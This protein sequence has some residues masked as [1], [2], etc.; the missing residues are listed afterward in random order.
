MPRT[1]ASG[2]FKIVALPKP[3][4]VAARCIGAIDVGTVDNS[5]KGEEKRDRMVLIIWELPTLTAVFSD[6]KGPEPFTIFTEMKFS[7]H[8]E[9]NFAKLISAWR[10]RPLT[11]EEKQYFDYSKLINKVGLISFQIKTKAKYREDNIIQATNENSKLKL[12]TIGP[13]PKPMRETTPAMI[14]KPI[15]WDWD[16]IIDG[17]EVF[18]QE[19]FKKIW[20]FIRAKMYTSDEWHEAPG[21]VNIDQEEEAQQEEP[22]QAPPPPQ[23]PTQQEET[24]GG[25]GDDW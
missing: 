22:Q 1:P 8:K 11:E 4:T 24:V 5:Y 13:L 21:V 10:N 17:D 6:E 9:S 18:D 16:K 19:K 2:N 12:G 20:R 15:L 23:Q 7:S 25:D 14:N 3:D